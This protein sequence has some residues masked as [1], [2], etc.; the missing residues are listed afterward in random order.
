MKTKK[1]LRLSAYIVAFFILVFL[2][3]YLS[4]LTISESIEFENEGYLTEEKVVVE[5][6]GKV[7]SPGKYSVPIGT[8][9]HD[10]I[11]M[12]NGI[13]N[14]GDPKSVDLSKLITDPCTITISELK[15]DETKKDDLQGFSNGEKC[16]IN[17]ATLS[18]LTMLPGVGD[19]LAADIINY[20]D[21]NG[22]FKSIQDIKNVR[23]IGNKKYDAL[24]DLI[25]VGG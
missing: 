22:K 23:G 13:T 1:I 6:N 10:V 12:A 3:M 14:D 17:K 25:K 7:K 24:K 20:R 19:T 15:T 21:V 9:L 11:Y 16:D 5:V 2:G 4:G 8:P 18:E